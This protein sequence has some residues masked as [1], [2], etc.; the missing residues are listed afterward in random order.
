MK[1][2]DGFTKFWPSVITVTTLFL[3]FWLLSVAVKSLPLGTS[4]MVW[5]G[6]G[7]VGA[8]ITGVIFFDEALSVTRVLAGSM[9]VGGILIMK[10]GS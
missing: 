5:A 10:M 6:V 2:S 9:I 3:S 8:F 7:A 4:Y 1:A